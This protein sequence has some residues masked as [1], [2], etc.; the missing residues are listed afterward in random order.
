VGGRVVGLWRYPVKS[1]GGEEAATFELDGRGL[2]ADRLWG[3]VDPVGKIASGKWTR[4]FRR[5]PGL[6]LHR[7]RLGEDG[8]PLLDLA[9]GRTARLEDAVAEELAGPG[10]RFAREGSVSHFDA[11]AVHLLTTATLAGIGAAAGED[12]EV[13]R[14][15]PNVLV[16]AGDEREESW[17]GRRIVVGAVELEVVG[18]APRCVMVNEAQPGLPRRRTLLRTIGRWNAVNAG[19]YASVV[20][21]GCISLGDAVRIA[22]GPLLKGS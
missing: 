13:E 15:R 6:L 19:V 7:A 16:D 21:P 20:R 2:V 12:V 1:L 11:G 17:I 10:W 5:V 4:R 18:P 3:L 9:D 22:P 14:L 8:L